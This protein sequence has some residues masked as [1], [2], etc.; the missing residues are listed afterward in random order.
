MT[1]LELHRKGGVPLPSLRLKLDREEIRIYINDGIQR[2]RA[3]RLTTGTRLK[4]T[5]SLMRSASMRSWSA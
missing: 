1:L 4:C 5:G 2:A 3:L